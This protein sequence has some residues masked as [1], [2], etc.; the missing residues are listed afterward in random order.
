MKTAAD[1]SV[2]RFAALV[3]QLLGLQPDEGRSRE[4]LALLTERA[5]GNVEGY[6]QRLSSG[7]GEEELRLLAERLT[8]GETYFLRHPTQLETLVNEVLPSLL[9]QHSTVRVLSAGSSSGEEAYSVAL[10]ARESN[11]RVDS[12]RLR[13]LGIDVNPRALGLARRAIYSP[14]ALRAV[15]P[16]L[17]QKWFQRTP[18]GF[19]LSPKLRDQVV[20]EERNLTADAPA[21]WAP[22]SFHVILCRNVLLYFAPELVRQIIARMAQALVPGGYLFLGPSETLRGISEDFELLRHG[23]AFYYRL[24]SGPAPTAP[25]L[26]FPEPS[27]TPVPLPAPVRSAASV[28]A[29]PPAPAPAPPPPPAPVR[30]TGLEEVLRLLELERYGEAE[31]RLESLPEAKQPLG[32]LLYA[33]L[34]LHAGRLREAEKLGRELVMQGI[35]RASANYLLGL[36]GEQSGDEAAARTRYAEAV[37]ADPTFALAHLRAGTLARRAG[38]MAAARVAL[39]MAL[40]LLPQE[41]ALHLSLFG[42]GFGRHGLMQVGLQELQACSTTEAS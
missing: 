25:P 5:G 15:S 34:H 35:E 24:R 42:G 26:P 4:L 41:D 22:E 36:C 16:A 23:D 14:W 1:I 40:S 7:P 31:G 2:T 39:R 33:V 37:R 28:L 9:R 27:R 30:H 17:R 19:A 21:F 18:Q 12:S 32:R 8:I 29:R 6:L 13:L 38:D 3:E 10:L 20:F 11:G